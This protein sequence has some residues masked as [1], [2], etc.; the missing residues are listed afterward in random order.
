MALSIDDPASGTVE[1]ATVSLDPSRPPMTPPGGLWL[2]KS[3]KNIEHRILCADARLPDSYRHLAGSA[4]AEMMF[5]DPPYNVAIGGNVSGLG[6]HR[7]GEFVMASGE[8]DRETF[9]NFLWSFLVALTALLQ[10]GAIAFVCMDWNMCRSCSLP[11]IGHSSP[12]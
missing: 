10:D 8:M 12:S 4:K 11:S 5:T 2:L 1:Q 9:T 3:R 6:A 7:H